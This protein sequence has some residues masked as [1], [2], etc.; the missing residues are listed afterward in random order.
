MLRPTVRRIQHVLELCIEYSAEACRL[1]KSPPSN[2]GL[3]PLGEDLY[4][5]IQSQLRRYQYELTVNTYV[6]SHPG[7]ISAFPNYWYVY[8]WRKGQG[9][10]KSQEA[11]IIP[12]I[13]EAMQRG[14]LEGLRRCQKPAYKGRHEVRP[15]CQ[16]W[17]YSTR[18][19]RLYCDQCAQTAY[20]QSPSGLEKNRERQKRHYEKHYRS[21]KLE[22]A[23]DAVCRY[24]AL[25]S[26]QRKRHPDWLTWVTAEVKKTKRCTREWIGHQVKIGKIAAG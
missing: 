2:G 21:D 4:R 6:S 1:R 8:R 15:A 13:L 14:Q 12:S 16:R 18:K 7:V 3:C 19:K 11:W 26:F 5:K 24:K 20:D 9:L 17:F 10:P 25:S 22:L 23:R